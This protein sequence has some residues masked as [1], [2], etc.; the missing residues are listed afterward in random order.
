[1]ARS[2]DSYDFL[3]RSFDSIAFN[4]SFLSSVNQTELKFDRGADLDFAV[5]VENYIAEQRLIAHRRANDSEVRFEVDKP[6]DANAN[7]VL[8]NG[9]LMRVLTHP[10]VSLGDS[11]PDKKA[12]TQELIR[13]LVDIVDGKPKLTLRTEALPASST[14]NAV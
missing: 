7:D 10:W 2:T 6:R 11:S 12:A 4:L 5:V 3:L 13:V 1:V 9:S 14:Q 8:Q